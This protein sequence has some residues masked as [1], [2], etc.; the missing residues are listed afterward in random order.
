MEL[1]ELTEDQWGEIAFRLIFDIHPFPHVAQVMTFDRVRSEEFGAAIQR[2]GGIVPLVSSLTNDDTLPLD[3]RQA[4]AEI[5]AS[6]KG[7][8]ELKERF[9]RYNRREAAHEFIR[10][11]PGFVWSKLAGE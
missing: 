10:A 2:S 1:S 9:A 7:E 5:L 3:M 8:E 6:S 4:L 11:N